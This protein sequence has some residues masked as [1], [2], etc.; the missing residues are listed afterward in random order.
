MLTF[1]FNAREFFSLLS[2][3]SAA[4]TYLGVLP[5]M[6]IPT[7]N[8]LTMESV[9]WVMGVTQRPW[10]YPTPL[11]RASAFPRDRQAYLCLYF[12]QNYSVPLHNEESM[13]SYKYYF[14]E[15]Q[16]T[17]VLLDLRTR[18]A[19]TAHK[20]YFY[21]NLSKSAGET[22]KIDLPPIFPPRRQWNRFRPKTRK[23]GNFELITL[24]NAIAWHVRTKSK[25]PW[26]RRL[27]KTVSEIQKAALS[28]EFRFSAP[29]NHPSTQIWK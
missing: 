26:F 21:S 8:S 7:V 10:F 14:S 22:S 13:H 16:I 1:N 15:E 27:T 12:C 3:C 6:T 19:K 17:E 20:K 9:G 29:Q 11:G 2:S 28:G 25:K 24:K 23:Q 5:I 18:A 4:T